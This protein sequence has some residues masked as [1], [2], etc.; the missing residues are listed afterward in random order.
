MK[1]A[2]V[3][4]IIS[5]SKQFQIISVSLINGINTKYKS[6]GRL[7]EAHLTKF[8]VCVCEGDRRQKDCVLPKILEYKLTI[9]QKALRNMSVS[10]IKLWSNTNSSYT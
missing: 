10:T 9:R 3:L 1:K 6:K 8:I 4:K 5:N 2:D 7:T